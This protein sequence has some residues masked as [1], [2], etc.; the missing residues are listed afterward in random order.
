MSAEE[1]A[2]K[3]EE[4]A[5]SKE[6]A[7]LVTLTE[8]KKKLDI[9]NLIQDIL[10]YTTLIFL[11]ICLSFPFWN[12]N[13]SGTV[14]F[15]SL[16][17]RTVDIAPT[18]FYHWDILWDYAYFSFEIIVSAV[19]LVFTAIIIV[20]IVKNVYKIVKGIFIKSPKRSEDKQSAPFP[21]PAL[22]TLSILT[23][24]TFGVGFPLMET[25]G[26]DFGGPLTSLYGPTWGLA[27]GW[28]ALLI[29]SILALIRHNYSKMLEREREEKEEE[30]GIV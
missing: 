3:A 17:Q 1:A 23:G 10:G 13:D 14:H 8:E 21:G 16:W 20:I 28:W 25:V 29:A 12:W 15:I 6:A 19:A 26:F 5:V 11:I 4:K 24:I 9:K 7:R 18:P 22:F 2:K 30:T 27:F